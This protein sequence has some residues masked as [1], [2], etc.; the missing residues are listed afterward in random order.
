[1]ENSKIDFDLSVLSLEELI[2]LRK[3]IKEYIVEVEFELEK[4][5]EE[6]GTDE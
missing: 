5:N 2:E 4:F 3:T 6:A 1:M